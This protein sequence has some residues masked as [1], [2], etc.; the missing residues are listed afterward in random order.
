M[1]LTYRRFQRAVAPCLA[2]ALFVSAPLTQAQTRASTKASA[3]SGMLTMMSVVL[4]LG[5]LSVGGQFIVAG[6]EASGSGTV[7]VLERVSDG[8]RASL[9]ATGE[10][11]GALSVA[12]GTT[13]TASTVASGWLL[14]SAGQ[15]VAFIP[16]E[17]GRALLHHER[18]TP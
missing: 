18:L 15:V 7:W 10:V 3:G 1:S 12:V 4:P 9:Q 13:L 14:L 17:V 2:V 5:F 11:A 6:L 16:N 8:A